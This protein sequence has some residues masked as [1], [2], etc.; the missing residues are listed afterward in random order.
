MKKK[1]TTKKKPRGRV[2]VYMSRKVVEGQLKQV[3][4]RLIYP[5]GRVMYDYGGWDH[6]FTRFD[7]GCTSRKTQRA[8]IE[9]ARQY[10]EDAGETFEYLGEV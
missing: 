4:V 5:N 10:S 9:A 2:K 1:R 6:I 8:A 7:E 3:R